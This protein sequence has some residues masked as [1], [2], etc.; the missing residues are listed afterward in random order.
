MKIRATEFLIGILVVVCFGL[1]FSAVYPFT[2]SSPHAATPPSERFT[3]SDADAYSTTGHIAVDGDLRLA[4]E[5]AVT[6]E[7]E[8]YQKVVEPNV[9]SEK[10]QPSPNGS[11]YQRLTITGRDRAER[12]HE[13]I[14]EEED[15]ILL[16][17]VRD[18]D[19][20]TFVVEHTTNTAREP[21]SGTASVF[22]NSLYVANY[23]RAGSNSSGVTV[24]EPRS[25]WY[26]ERSTYRIT[27]AS[28]GV[29]A[30]A[31]THVVR[32]ANVSW[33]VTD[34]AGTY[35]EFMLSRL[36]SDD[37]TTY[38]ITFEFNPNDTPLERPAWV[39]Q[40]DSG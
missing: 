8:W 20:V 35:P 7:G 6:A 15:R 24:Y 16:R 17:E 19:R 1:V 33:E 29:Y 36:F 39:G 4:F 25:G 40:T 31:D 32:S 3:V 5:G 2:T 11:V 27:E 28:G 12:I 34:P 10:Y 14:T 13:Q 37:P 26:E 9:S 18:G 23:G 38:R 30:N 21:V 22:V